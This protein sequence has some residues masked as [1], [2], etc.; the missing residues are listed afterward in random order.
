MFGC[1]PYG[2]RMAIEESLDVVDSIRKDPFKLKKKNS[3]R[4]ASG[5]AS[6]GVWGRAVARVAES[7]I[8]GWAHLVH[9][10]S[11]PLSS[12]VRLSG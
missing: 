10:W 7:P 12:S 3:F 8:G 4:G 5:R 6:R 11:P 1:A 9:L 2:E